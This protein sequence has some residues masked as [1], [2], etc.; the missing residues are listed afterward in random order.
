M[1]LPFT[2]VTYNLMREARKCNE[3]QKIVLFYQQ[4][5]DFF[6]GEKL[7][8]YNLDKDL[9]SKLNLPHLS[10][11]AQVLTDVQVSQGERC[12]ES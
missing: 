1:P 9:G 7:I 8:G 4:L 5:Q 12:S 11:I 10:P 6:W 2:P 3:L